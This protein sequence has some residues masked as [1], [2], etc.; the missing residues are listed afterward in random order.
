MEFKE[1]CGIPKSQLSQGFESQADESPHSGENIFN[2]EHVQQEKVL[3]KWRAESMDGFPED[4][5]GPE[6]F[7][8]RED[9]TPWRDKRN[10][11]RG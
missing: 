1:N 6:G 10:N 7:L 8:S 2:P 3:A 4:E 11:D 9:Q 5:N